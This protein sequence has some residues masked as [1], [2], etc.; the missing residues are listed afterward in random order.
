MRIL[1]LTFSF[2]KTSSGNATE[3]IIDELVRKGNNVVVVCGNNYAKKKDYPVM[4]IN[5]KP[6]K[7]SK[8]LKTIGN[9][10]KK[11]LNYYFWEY[12]AKK[13]C[14]KLIDSFDPHYIYSRGSPI[15]SMIVGDYLNSI[16]GKPHI[17]HFADPIPPTKDW[18]DMESERK[19]NLKTIKPIFENVDASFFVTKE[20][21]TYQHN[22][23]EEVI[24]LKKSFISPNAILDFKQF[25]SPKNDKIIF[26]YVGTF[27]RQRNPKLI[28]DAFIKF[29]YNKNDVEFHIFG[30]KSNIE[31][32]KSLEITHPK[33]KVFGPTDSVREVFEK[34]N[35]LIDIDAK[36]DE[37]VFISGKLMEYLSFDRHVLLISQFNSPSYNLTKNLTNSV[38]RT[39]L[40]IDDIAKGF[41]QSYHLK[42]NE[43]DFNER[44]KLYSKYS[45]ENI[46][47]KLEKNIEEVLNA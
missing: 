39:G 9:F 3:R 23:L 5:P 10:F 8:V 30:N 28:S 20:M 34:S 36:V 45:L 25:G 17:V 16:T 4:L 33:I 6:L 19:K 42:W 40:N 2:G 1:I 41:L 26:S 13:Y 7:P 37:P 24:N 18:M 31:L 22:I 14:L 47:E 32:F 43:N 12:R 27:S 38:I 21:L 11:E 44:M 46:V 15:T 29:A 35:I